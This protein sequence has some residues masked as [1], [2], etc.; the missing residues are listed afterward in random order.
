MF[1]PILA[2]PRRR[3]ARAMLAFLL[4]AASPLA[5]SASTIKAGSLTVGSDL[6]YPPYAYMDAG[7]PAGFDADFSRLLADKLSLQPV[8]VDT[9]FPDLILGM[10]AHRFDTVASALYVTPERSKLIDFIPYLKTGASLVVLASSPYA[11]AAP[12]ALCGKRVASIKGASWTPKLQKVSREAC[13]PKG[14]GEIKVL[15]FP[16]SPEAMMALRSQAADVMIEDAA[17]V[18]GMLAQSQNTLKISSTT[19]L[20]PIVIGL[21]INKG[22]QALQDALKG[23]L[24]R[25]SD[26]GEYQTLLARYG[27]EAPTE[28]EVQTALSGPAK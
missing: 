16:T 10:R 7:K 13:Q 26:S 12:D 18:H 19:L 21:G 27:L 20:Y 2:A 8:F 1:T 28:A 17:V 4:C 11:P 15:E 3:V 25:A 22:S 5:F 9:R 6:T 14:L 23:A 24:Q